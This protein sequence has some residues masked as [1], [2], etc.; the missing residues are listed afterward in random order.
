MDSR[1]GILALCAFGLVACAGEAPGTEDTV[2]V[3]EKDVSGPAF[4]SISST[5]ESTT[6]DAPSGVAE[7]DFLI[8]VLEVDADPA[9][10]TPPTGWTLLVD[11]VA[12]SGS[13]AFTPYFHAQV[14]THVATSS[15][16]STY[17]FAAD[18][19][20]YVDVQVAAYTGVSSVDKSGAWMGIGDNARVP[21]LF[22]SYSN[23]LF[24]VF[25]SAW[26]YGEWSTATGMTSRSNVDSNSLQD[27]VLSSSGA[28]GGELVSTTA[29]V[30]VVSAVSILLH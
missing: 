5:T 16:P 1:I 10:V 25:L 4:K 13:E 26:D 14:Y 23:D 2:T 28:V 6:V 15:E 9:G 17:T 21:R 29:P 8:A 18:P 22:P 11:E 7:G 12:G 27:Q 19:Y 3:S 24:V 20:T 30:T